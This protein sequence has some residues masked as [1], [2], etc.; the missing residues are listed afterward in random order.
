MNFACVGVWTAPWTAEAR[1]LRLFHLFH[2]FRPSMVGV[3]NGPQ[4][5]QVEAGLNVRERV[6]AHLSTT[7]NRGRVEEN[8]GFLRCRCRRE[9]KPLRWETETFD[10]CVRSTSSAGLFEIPSLLRCKVKH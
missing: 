10:R 2:L 9:Q 7:S 6:S 5:A 3:M 1:L 8:V 4:Q